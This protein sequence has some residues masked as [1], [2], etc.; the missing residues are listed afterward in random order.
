MGASKSG[1]YRNALNRNF[2][3]KQAVVEAPAP[4]AAQTRITDVKAPAP[5]AAQTRIADPNHSHW[6]YLV[7]E[8]VWDP[9]TQTTKVVKSTTKNLQD[10][11]LVPVRSN[12]LSNSSTDSDAKTK[13]AAFADAYVKNTMQEQEKQEIASSLSGPRNTEAFAQT[14]PSGPYT[15]VKVYTDRNGPAVLPAGPAKNPWGIVPI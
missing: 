8:R 7:E 1:S 2:A 12:P 13:A 15:P 11:G 3:R 4:Q 14:P 6:D 5:Q 10:Q 9:A